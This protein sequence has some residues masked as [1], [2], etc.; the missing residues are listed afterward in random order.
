MGKNILR[1]FFLIFG[2]LRTSLIRAQDSLH[3][4]KPQMADAMRSNGKIYVVVAV[5]L[6]V[7][8]GLFLFLISLDRK[9]NRLEKN[10]A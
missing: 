8:A 10:E 6:I 1:L 9:L 7:L 4:E 3:K 2:L 5:L